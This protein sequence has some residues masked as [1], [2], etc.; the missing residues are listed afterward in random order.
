MKTKIIFDT[1]V[2][3]D[4]LRLKQVMKARDLLSFLWDYDQWLRQE[5]K[6]ASEEKPEGHVGALYEARDKL[7]EMMVEH[8]I[9]FEE[10][11]P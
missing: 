6:Y 3:D 4:E 8:N 5:T 7:Y 11:Y 2:E 10:L 1:E 9:S